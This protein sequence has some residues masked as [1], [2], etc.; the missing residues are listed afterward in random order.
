MKNFYTFAILSSLIFSNRLFAEFHKQIDSKEWYAKI[1]K[2]EDPQEKQSVIEGMW[3]VKGIELSP[4]SAKRLRDAIRKKP[5]DPESREIL[6]SYLRS[7]RFTNPNENDEFIANY[8]WFCKHL[9]RSSAFSTPLLFQ[10]DGVDINKKALEAWEK[11][12]LENPNDARI[13]GNA[14]HQFYKKSDLEKRLHYFAMAQAVDSRN[15]E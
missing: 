4:E 10:S 2:I 12:A 9:P 3:E 14:G 5:N 13:L 8:F 7:H 15:S 6:F 1:N 11:L